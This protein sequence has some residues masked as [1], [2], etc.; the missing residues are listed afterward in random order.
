MWVKFSQEMPDSMLLI[1]SFSENQQVWEHPSYGSCYV[2]IVL[3]I[4]Q[5]DNIETRIYPNPVTDILQIRME[6][7]NNRCV[8]IEVISLSGQVVRSY[9]IVGQSFNVDMAD[10]RPGAYFIR[11]TDD[12][13]RTRTFKTLRQ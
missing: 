3:D 1:C 7:N 5:P 6:N 13:H 10:L 2:N 12:T 4:N 9:Q 11:I 8:L